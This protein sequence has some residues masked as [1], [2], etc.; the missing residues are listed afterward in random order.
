M[1]WLGIEMGSWA[2]WFG[3]ILTAVGIYI[4]IKQSKIKLKL[5]YEYDGNN[6]VITITNKSNIDVK[7][8][9]AYAHFYNKR[10]GGK[11][12]NQSN[13]PMIPA[14][15]DGNPFILR[16]KNTE[17]SAFYPWDEP[18]EDSVKKMYVEYG[19]MVLGGKIIKNKLRVKIKRQ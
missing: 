11:L 13:N 19:F 9:V 14:I 8:D 17:K 7:V 5:G 16:A 12:L 6:F 15:E 2:D 3:G 10:I 1:K 4:A 18:I